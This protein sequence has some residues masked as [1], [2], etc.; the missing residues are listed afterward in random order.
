MIVWLA[1]NSFLLLVLGLAVFLTIRQ[2][3]ILL[4]QVGPVGAR[5]STQGPRI[6][7]NVMPHVSA[8]EAAHGVVRRQPALYVFVSESC[9]ICASVRSASEAL[10]RYWAGRAAIRLVYDEP[11]RRS[12]AHTSEAAGPSL[13]HDRELRERLGVELVPF[14]VMTDGRGQVIGKGVVNDASQLESLL[15]MLL[16]EHETVRIRA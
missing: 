15:E 9:V 1:V 6:G 10:A 3:G 5:G 16:R 7:E 8:L 4:N 11:P 13:W 12:A 14:A 2:V